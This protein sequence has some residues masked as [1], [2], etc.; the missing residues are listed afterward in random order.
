MSESERLRGPS[1]QVED[2]A[3]HAGKLTPMP[4]LQERR[5]AERLLYGGK[6][7]VTWAEGTFQAHSADLSQT[8][9]FIE[10]SNLLPVGTS[11]R[12]KFKVSGAA[13]RHSVTAE[14]RVARQMTTD[15]AAAQGLSPGL[16]IRF[17]WVPAGDM[18]LFHFI[19][20]RLRVIR[21]P[22]PSV[23][24]RAR[25]HPAT[26]V[27]LPVFW[28][29]DPNLGRGGYLQTL[30]TSGAFLETR[31]PAPPGT[32]IYL[33]FELP[34][35][36]VARNARATAVVAYVHPSGRQQA[37]GMGIAFEVS[38]LDASIV[39]RFVD[40]RLGHKAT[41]EIKP[42]LDPSELELEFSDTEAASAPPVCLGPFPGGK[43]LALQSGQTAIEAGTLSD[44][45]DNSP[46]PDLPIK[47]LVVER[48]P[49]DNARIKGMLAESTRDFEVVEVDRVADAL[50]LMQRFEFNTVMLDLAV[51]EGGSLEALRR[52]RIA[53]SEIPIIVMTSRH[54]EKMAL[55]AVRA[56][57]QDYLV[58]GEWNLQLLVR[59]ILHA[60]E[61]HRLL[62]ELQQ[63][64]REQQFLA[65]HDSLTG[66]YNRSAFEDGLRRD[67]L[68][69]QRNGKKACLF[70][71]DLDG[72]KSV[73]D[74]LGHATGD[75]VLKIVAQRLSG[76]MRRSDLVAR[77]GGD[78]FVLLMQD[79][80]RREVAA[81]LAEKV[82]ELLSQPFELADQVLELTSSV[83]IAIYPD[84]STAPDGLIR[85]ADIA[86]YR[87]KSHD[88]NRYEFFSKQGATHD[89][90]RG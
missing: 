16:G 41:V 55:E 38:T 86:M 64:R 85:N 3:V 32:H 57:A 19:S 81:R 5:L 29:T 7:V 24:E 43:R 70:Y 83:G 31:T 45:A 48:S 69:A 47:V 8:G 10:T 33:W 21:A 11:V 2:S 61:R 36:G 39:E 42:T 18:A 90:C 54:D 15:E 56:G 87:A 17:E 78:E 1:P 76:W 20:D 62:M 82:L 4:A 22:R 9:V 14:G 80:T 77:L 72:F 34:S 89:C 26:L 28:G 51:P 67:L 68:Y 12:L 49:D 75:E 58:K 71:L 44:F 30:S 60:L 84:D 63:A 66:L 53:A 35:A 25:K 27:A 23:V 13:Q 65:T 79:V 88:K 74:R 73:N 52:V 46:P 40:A 59:T 6:I 37:P 50:Q